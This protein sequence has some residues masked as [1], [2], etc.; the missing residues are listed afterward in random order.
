MNLTGILRFLRKE[1]EVVVAQLHANRLYISYH[2]YYV[3]LCLGFSS[4]LKQSDPALKAEKL[5]RCSLVPCMDELAENKIAYVHEWGYCAI[6]RISYLGSRLVNWSGFQ[7]LC[8]ICQLSRERE[9][10]K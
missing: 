8:N 4:L 10:K 7:Y 2:E 6:M 9:Q 1:K 3:R 5:E